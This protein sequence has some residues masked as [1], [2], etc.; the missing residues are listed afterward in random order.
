[1]VRTQIQ[2]TEEQ[3]QW[4]RDFAAARQV[5]MAQAVRMALDTI[6]QQECQTDRLELMRRASDSFGKWGSGLKDVS[7]NHDR[8]LEEAYY[9]WHEDDSS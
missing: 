9:D 4:L 2:L 3:A 5:S 7:A 6:R 1:M 8:Y